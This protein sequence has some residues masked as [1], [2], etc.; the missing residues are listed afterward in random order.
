MSATSPHRMLR[1]YKIF[2][3]L[4]KVKYE[5][6]ERDADGEATGRKVQVGRDGEDKNGIAICRILASDI[7]IAR[8]VFYSSFKYTNMIDLSIES[9]SEE[10][11]D[12]IVD[13]WSH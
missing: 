9:I 8:S 13:L 1:N 11:L 4:F 6:S 10:K 3:F 7:D 2:V 12:Y 5:I